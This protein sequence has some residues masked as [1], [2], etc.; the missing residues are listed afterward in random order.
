MNIQHH[1]IDKNHPTIGKGIGDLVRLLHRQTPISSVTLDTKPHHF[2]HLRDATPVLQRGPTLFT[3]SQVKAFNDHLALTS[4]PAG[5]F[6]SY[7]QILKGSMKK[8]CNRPWDEDLRLY[9]LGLG[10]IAPLTGKIEPP[11]EVY[12]LQMAGVDPN[13]LYFK[14]KLYRLRNCGS[15]QDLRLAQELFPRY[16]PWR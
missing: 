1:R 3:S 9:C 15:D 6:F 16:G 14:R 5:T 4:E 12:A 2:L 13:S 7:L 8:E 10:L 11:F